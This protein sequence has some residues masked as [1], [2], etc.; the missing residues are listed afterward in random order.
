L[1]RQNVGERRYDPNWLSYGPDG[2]LNQDNPNTG[3]DI[4]TGYD[5]P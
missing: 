1:F 2:R 4:R 3:G 5:I